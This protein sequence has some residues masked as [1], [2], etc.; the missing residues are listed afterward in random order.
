[1]IRSAPA[2]GA[3]VTF[4]LFLAG[5]LSAALC[6]AFVPSGPAIGGGEMLAV[7]MNV[8]NT[9]TFGNPF[10]QAETGPTG[11]V[12]PLYPFVLSL[13]IRVFGDSAAIAGVMLA[14]VLSGMHAA[15]MPR[16][17][18]VMLGAVAP[19]VWGA[20]LFIVLPAMKM[21][22]AWEAWASGVAMMAFCVFSHKR[23]QPVWSGICV[24]LLA[25]LNPLSAAVAMGWV[26]VLCTQSGTARS[27]F[28]HTAAVAVLG[29][30]VCMPW[31]L[32]NTARIGA[33]S[34][35][36][37]LGMTL[38]ASHNDCAQPNIAEEIRHGCYQAYH[39]AG[40]SAELSMLRQMGEAEYDRYSTSR[41]VAWMSSHFS[42][43]AGLTVMRA[44]EFWL[45]HRTYHVYA[46]SVW[47]VTLLGMFGAWRLQR[48]GASL[49]LVWAGLLYSFPYY[50]VVSDIRYRYPILWMALLLA[51][52]ALTPIGRKLPAGFNAF[53]VDG[54]AS[55]TPAD[56]RRHGLAERGEHLRSCQ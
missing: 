49:F 39:P 53:V 47:S 34:I 10:P 16:V 5:C 50:L 40:S 4:L 29:L 48:H 31:M 22:P 13:L 56:E 24:G 21:M 54:G 41:A 27:A 36:N 51:G 11:V 33:F 28:R 15:L 20:V 44:I 3:D 17:S 26:V 2:L 7:A 43:A 25:L 45:P 19:G 9:G 14:V 38:L 42:E 23:R 32:R 35:K 30:L 37:N 52:V 8:A 46:Y 1:L 12:A 18:A 55:V 6:F